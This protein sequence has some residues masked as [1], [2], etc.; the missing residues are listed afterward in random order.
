MV[1]NPFFEV[2]LG[3]LADALP[4]LAVEVVIVAVVVVAVHAQVALRVHIPGH[5]VQLR[6]QAV[7]DAAA[8]NFPVAGVPPVPSADV[9]NDENGRAHPDIQIPALIVQIVAV[10]FLH[11]AVFF[12][13]CQVGVVLLESL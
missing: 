8:F 3:L 4:V 6:I 10:E 9:G 13:L 5:A 1:E 11:Q 12:L 2:L 7:L